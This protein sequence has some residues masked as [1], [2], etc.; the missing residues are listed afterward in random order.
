MLYEVITESVRD[1][2]VIHADKTI[3]IPT[4]AYFSEAVEVA[5]APPVSG[6]SEVALARDVPPEPGS[7]ALQP[8]IPES[9]LAAPS[10]LSADSG[11]VMT[12][13]K[14]QELALPPLPR[15]KSRNNFV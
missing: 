8:A 15:P 10:P 14:A 12:G 1:V 13:D 5:E 2:N 3:L 11:A 9:Q 4:Q 7:K 6:T